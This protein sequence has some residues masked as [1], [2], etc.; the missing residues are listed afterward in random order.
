MLAKEHKVLAVDLD[1][2]GNLTSLL[3]GKNIYDFDGQTALEAMK[4]QDALKYAHKVNENLDIL[5]SNDYM[6][7]LPRFLLR[8]Y[9]GGRS[10][11]CL[12]ETLKEAKQKYD[13]IIIDCPPAL[14]EHTINAL[15]TSDEV[16]ICFETS[17]FCFDAIDRFLETYTH[18]KQTVNPKVKIAGILCNIID[19]RSSD[20][21]EFINAVDVNYPGQR[22]EAM[23]KRQ[24]STRR[25]QLRG[26]ED[27]PELAHAIKPYQSFVKELLERVTV[28]H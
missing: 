5:T 22:F 17:K 1:S 24:A 27:N 13:F 18:A 14:S 6:A 7:T 20:T 21:M 23:I 8:D 12:D 26:F 25:L 3:T 11:L 9:K 4:E 10:T 16:V 28:K 15:C 2:Q 19:M